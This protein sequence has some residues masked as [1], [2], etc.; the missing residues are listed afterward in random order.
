MNLFLRAKH[1]QLFLL[2]FGIPFIFQ[3]IMVVGVF[4][5]IANHQ[6]TAIISGIFKFFPLLMLVFIGAIFGWQWSVA[7]GLQKL[8]PQ[9][10]KMKVTKFKIFFVIPLVYILFFIGFIGLF[11]T[12]V[13]GNN[14]FPGNSM[15]LLF[16]LIF[17]LHM[18]AMFC[19]FYCI[20]FV[21]KT[22]KTVELQRPVAFGDFIGE[23]FMVWFSFIGIWILQPRINKYIGDYERGVSHTEF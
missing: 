14:G 18:F 8:V 2:T 6:N 4:S 12:R 15:F 3:I 7:I 5:S 1:W 23:F 22:I 10:I 17:L 13:I 19:I 9:G 21:A 20:Y 11:I 16:P